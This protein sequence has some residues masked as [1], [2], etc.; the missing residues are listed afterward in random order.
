MKLLLFQLKQNK[1]LNLVDNPKPK[2]FNM[3]DR[4]VDLG[5]IHLRPM[6]SADLDTFL[7]LGSR[8]CG[9]LHGRPS[10]S[11]SEL[12]KRF[13]SF[14]KEFAFRPESEIWVASMKEFDYAGHLWLYQTTNRFNGNNELWIWDVTVREECRRAGVGK[15]LM[16]FASNRSKELRCSEL[17][18]MV[19][20]DNSI[21]RR[22][23]ASC[24]FQPKAQMLA[25]ETG[26]EE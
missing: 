22:L 9:S 25:I 16:Q 24:G 17:W 8:T 4:I 7:Q 1:G 13:Q 14:V 21:A 2:I 11:F 5:T 12:N 19:A 10:L 15:K 6:Q 26:D 20:E 23:Y 3:K 18:L